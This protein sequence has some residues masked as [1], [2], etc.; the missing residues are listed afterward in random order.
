MECF[1]P[2][3]LFVML[4]SAGNSVSL[5]ILLAVAPIAFGQQGTI[6][7]TVID[8]SGSSVAHAEVRLALDG[9]EPDQETQTPESG[10]FSF[11]NVAPG[12]YRLS[13]AAKG[14]AVKTISG[15][16]HPGEVLSLPQT[17]LAID[18]LTTQVNVTPQTQS[19]I[20]QAQIKMAEQQRLIGILPNFF[21]N[22]DQDAAPLSAKQKLELTARTWLDP[23][24]FVINGMIAGVWQA[25][26]THKGF[27]QG[28]RGY[29]KR[30]GASFADYGTSLLLEKVVATTL[31]KQDPRYFYKRIGTKRS[32]V[33][34]AI[35]RT[36]V[37]RG[38]NKQDQFCYSSFINR[39]G[40]GFVTNYYYPAADRDKS[41]VILRNSA[42][43]IG[44]DAIG[45]IFQEFVARKF[46]SKKH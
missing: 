24:A 38:D 45:N 43:G 1:S 31:F 17:A 35:S 28:G 13:F 40:T 2:Y 9:R 42:M 25:Q 46:T 10:S 30:Y 33:F 27:G 6:S 14:F 34:Y 44:F 22:Y 36:V 19:E 37:C 39:L 3:R 12:T 41:G 29:A 20:A 7:G 15:D 11:S 23:S 4:R 8:T 16:L 18:T 26:N 5:L 21:A 32:R